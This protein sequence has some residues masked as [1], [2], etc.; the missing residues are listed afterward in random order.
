VRWQVT[1]RAG[2]QAGSSRSA[3][4][5]RDR[6]QLLLGTGCHPLTRAEDGRGDSAPAGSC[7][8]V[9]GHPGWERG[10]GGG[11]GDSGV[12][13][14]WF[15]GARWRC[16]CRERLE[17]SRWEGEDGQRGAA[18]GAC[19]WDP[20]CG[21]MPAAPGRCGHRAGTSALPGQASAGI[22]GQHRALPVLGGVAEPGVS[23]D[24]TLL[25]FAAA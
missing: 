1:G 4:S 8:P 17:V 21:G 5:L 23:A 15:L 25:S 7:L 10:L 14:W 12:G 22:A 6:H 19:A 16:L 3:G 9:S 13:G 11:K 2:G 18:P 24:S 20:C